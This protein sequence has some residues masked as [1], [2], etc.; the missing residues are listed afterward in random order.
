MKIKRYNYKIAVFLLAIMTFS[1]TSCV[2]ELEEM[3][4][5]PNAIEDLPYGMQFTRL[6]LMASGTRYEMRRAALGWALPAIQQLADIN[7]TTNMLPGDK[8][9]D[10]LDY[11]SSLFDRA[12]LNE[13][14]DL[15]DYLKRTSEDPE[16]T[17]HYAIGRIWSVLSFH[18]TTDIYGDIPYSEAGQ[19]YIENIW[20]P[21]YDAQEDIYMHMLSE[22]EAAANLLNESADVVGDQD[23]VYGGDIAQWRRLAYSLMMRL[24]FRLV[25]VDLPAAEVWV[26]KAIEGGVMNNLLDVCKTE[27]QLL[28]GWTNSNPIGESFNVDKFMRLSDTFVSWMEDNGD[29][30]LEI[31]SWV[32][33]GAPHQ[34]L[35]NGLDPVTLETEGP[36]G[37]DLL[38]YSQINQS[39]VDRESP[40]MFMTYAEVEFMLAEA[41]LR[42]WHSGDAASH[43]ENGVRAAMLNWA[44]YGVEAPTVAQID[45]Y[46]AANPF[47]TANGMEMIGEQYWAATFLN[48]WE[49]YANW[50]RV[51][52][53]VLTPVNYPGNATN[54]TIPRRLKYP[55]SEYTLNEENVRAADSR[56]GPNEFTTR[57]WWDR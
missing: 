23:I 41:A 26:K 12:Y 29:P 27:H 3:N 1:I 51:E 25:K 31:I 34:G 13:Y 50:R 49:G 30:R 38:D 44:F 8:Y 55:D 2:D 10:F 15:A 9:I 54:G 57:V 20:S 16:A 5:N 11:H 35:P 17:N 48:P 40:F 7:V 6:Q 4:Q 36:A 52:Y 18:R 19:G 37:G 39:L 56:Q 24:G 33:S 42:G 43:Y 53:P 22:L 21:K 14:K 32:E 46:L 47:N 28:G 45:A